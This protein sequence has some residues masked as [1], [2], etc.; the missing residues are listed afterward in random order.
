M[1]RFR[2]PKDI[3]SS[4]VTAYRASLLRQHP[5]RKFGIIILSILIAQMSVWFLYE[6]FLEERFPSS[7]HI[8]TELTYLTI[9]LVLILAS[10]LYHYSY[11]PLLRS[12]EN[13][14]VAQKQLE[15]LNE[16]LSV[17]SKAERKAHHLTET[18]LAANQAFSQSLDLDSIAETFLDYMFDFVP[19]DE[20]SILAPATQGTWTFLKSVYRESGIKIKIENS[21]ILDEEGSLFLKAFIAGKQSML[22]LDTQSYK[23]WQPWTEKKGSR[24]WLGLPLIAN[25][26][27]VA[28]CE[29]DKACPNFFTNEHV[30]LAE[31]LTHVAAKALQNAWLFEQVREGRERLKWLS[32]RL[33]KVQEGE[34]RYI[35]RELHDEAGQGLALLR[36]KLHLLEKDVHHPKAVMTGINELGRILD[37]ISEGLRCLA[38]RLRPVSLDHFGIVPA[39]RQQI[40]DIATNYNIKAQFE[41][42]DV[43]GRLPL[44][45]ETAVYRIVQEGITN[46][47]RHGQA[48]R[49]DII[50]QNR[51]NKLVVIIEDNGIGFLPETVNTSE[52]LGLIGMAERAEMLNGTMT[53]ESTPGAGTTVLIEVPL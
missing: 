8:I 18:L 13:L 25:D 44:E 2:T 15:N 5:V 24:S 35:A 19:Y 14:Q 31:M 28:I 32:H 7:Q 12:N 10:I 16:E 52:H 22:V 34:R 40:E 46:I 23:E 42:T 20:A 53:I 4:R 17:I 41:S 49:A 33:V 48:T 1:R 37:D 30:K 51:D 21:H 38:V 43:N 29:L 9:T 6:T 26:S 27:V 47:V 39:L 45:L 50:L 36:I 3:N 11:R